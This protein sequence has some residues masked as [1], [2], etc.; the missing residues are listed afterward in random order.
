MARILSPRSRRKISQVVQ[1]LRSSQYISRSARVQFEFSVSRTV[2]C[3]EFL[4]CDYAINDI[5]PTPHGAAVSRTLL[6][7][8]RRSKGISLRE[9]CR[10]DRRFSQYAALSPG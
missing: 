7:V 8:A 3:M 5:R 2:C 10:G 6:T 4:Q 9:H 1:L